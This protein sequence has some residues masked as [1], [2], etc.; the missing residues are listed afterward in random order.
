[1][2]AV[3]SKMAHFCKLFGVTFQRTIFLTRNKVQYRQENA[4]RKESDISTAVQTS[5]STHEYL[6]N[7]CSDDRFNNS[8]TNARGTALYFNIDST[9]NLSE[10][11]YFT[12]NEAR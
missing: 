7:S 4:L 1:V 5:L 9:P 8:L 6:K 12:H 3:S 11:F 10:E 2:A